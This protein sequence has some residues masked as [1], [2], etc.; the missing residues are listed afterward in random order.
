MRN[1]ILIGFVYFLCVASN[2][3]AYLD[4]GTGS[5]FLQMFIAGIVSA[6]FAV[7]MCWRRIVNF[8]SGLFK[9]KNNDERR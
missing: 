5:V 1:I 7:K 4:P 2:A 9:G 6:L 8:F 3:H